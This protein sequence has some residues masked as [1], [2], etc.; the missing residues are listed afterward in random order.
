MI[1]KKYLQTLVLI[2]CVLLSKY[3]YPMEE[4]EDISQS[5]IVAQASTSREVLDEKSTPK[6]VTLITDSTSEIG[7]GNMPAYFVYVCLE[8]MDRSEL[9]IY[10]EKII[11]TLVGIDVK[12]I[13][14]Y[15]NFEHLE[16]PKPEGAAVIE[17]PSMKA[18]K[19]WYDSPA[20]RE[21]RQHRQNGAKYIGILMEGGAL[22]A[23][24]RMPQTINN[25][26]TK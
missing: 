25:Q 11:P 19:S 20:Y 8:V 21:I 10:W 15:T 16:G 2:G 9:E 7:K 18:A 6:E 23:H 12:P 17:F 1:I 3:S 22:P 26:P 4:I 13:A 5:N 14:A 24:L